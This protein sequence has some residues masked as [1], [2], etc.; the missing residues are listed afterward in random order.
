[1]GAAQAD[2]P[3]RRT[4]FGEDQSMKAVPDITEREKA[5]FAVAAGRYDHGCGPIE[6][7][8]ERE[9]EASFPDVLRV[10]RRIEVDLPYL[11]VYTNKWTVNPNP[12]G[13]RSRNGLHCSAPPDLAIDDVPNR[14]NCRLPLTFALCSP[15]VTVC[16]NGC[17]AQFVFNSCPRAAP[18]HAGVVAGIGLEWNSVPSPKFVQPGCTAMTNRIQVGEM[19]LHDGVEAYTKEGPKFT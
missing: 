2:N 6:F 1:V 19:L 10:F 9:R 8:G 5:G 16:T 13:F 12:K 14:K 3:H 11:I 7:S 18:T 4:G 17:H 15:M